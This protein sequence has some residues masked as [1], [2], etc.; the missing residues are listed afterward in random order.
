MKVRIKIVDE[1]T[2]FYKISCAGQEIKINKIYIDSEPELFQ[3]LA[4]ISLKHVEN[5]D[6]LDLLDDYDY[7]EELENLLLCS[8]SL[9]LNLKA[10]EVVI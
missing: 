3:Q 5:F 2:E 4:Y 1:S 7:E 6:K 8:N 9:V 10:E